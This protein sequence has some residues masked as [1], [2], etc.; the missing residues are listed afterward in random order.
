VWDTCATRKRTPHNVRGEPPGSNRKRTT[1][2]A[3]Q[4]PPKGAVDIELDTELASPLL[5]D[6]QAPNRTRGH[7]PRPP[8][9]TLRKAPEVV[10]ALE[11]VEG[12]SNARDVTT[13]LAGEARQHAHPVKTLEGVGT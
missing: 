1:Y 9:I 4:H 2:N 11:Q 13:N 12:R 7:R 6:I 8:P 10:L 5:D 3:T